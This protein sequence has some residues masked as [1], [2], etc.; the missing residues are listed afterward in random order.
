MKNSTNLAITFFFCLSVLSTTASAWTVSADFEEGD[1]GSIAVGPDAFSHTSNDI[2]LDQNVEGDEITEAFSGKNVA[3]LD[4][5]ANSYG[6]GTWGGILDF[7]ETL[8]KGDEIWYK[9]SIFFPEGFDYNASPHL[10]FLRIRTPDGHLDWYIDN[11]GTANP[12]KFI[13]EGEQVWSRFGGEEDRIEF[14][15]W[16]TYEMYIKLD[17]VRSTEGGEAMVRVWKN[18]ILLGTFLDRLTLADET[19]IANY[20]LLFTYWNGGNPPAQYLYVDDIVITT[21]TPSQTDSQGNHMIGT[22][23]SIMDTPVSPLPPTQIRVE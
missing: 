20:A 10:K 14:G 1:T 16:E 9:V 3:K 7:P 22:N 5:R 15:K 6:F 17:N 23:P 19:T 21:D 11:E 2:I 12:F 18:G 8:G 4:I 13:Y